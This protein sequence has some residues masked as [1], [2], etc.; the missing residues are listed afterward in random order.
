MLTARRI[1]AHSLGVSPSSGWTEA[2]RDGE[3]RFAASSSVGQL[4]PEAGHLRR[5]LSCPRTAPQVV[6]PGSYQGLAPRNTHELASFV[7]IDV[8]DEEPPRLGARPE[9]GEGPRHGRVVLDAVADDHAADRSMRLYLW[10]LPGEPDEAVFFA[11]VDR[12]RKGQPVPY[13]FTQGDECDGDTFEFQKDFMERRHLLA[14]VDLAGN[15]SRPVELQFAARTASSRPVRRP[16]SW[17]CLASTAACPR[18]SSP[19]KSC[20][21]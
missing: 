14:L 3:G 4:P 12:R 8:I 7:T 13:I 21:D 20:R 19:S 1:V 6:I 16:V 10:E 5:A 9:S 17:V 2:S 15:V 11:Y 18:P